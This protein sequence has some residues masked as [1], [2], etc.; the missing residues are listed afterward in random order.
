MDNMN[1]N[2]IVAAT[3]GIRVVLFDLGI[4]LAFAHL[5]FPSFVIYSMID[6]AIF[7]VLLLAIRTEHHLLKLP[8]TLASTEIIIACCFCIFSR[9]ID[10]NSR[11]SFMRDRLRMWHGDN[12]ANQLTTMKSDQKTAKKINA[13]HQVIPAFTF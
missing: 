1:D 9:A 8:V 2:T 7:L 4:V 3:I 11:R 12:M 6:E 13:K 10:L 5:T